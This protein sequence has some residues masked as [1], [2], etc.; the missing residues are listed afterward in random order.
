MAFGLSKNDRKSEMIGADSVVVFFDK[1][2]GRGH[3]VDYYLG[4]VLK[5][6]KINVLVLKDILIYSFF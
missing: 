5:I 3:A 6:Q 1:T 4:K 2:T